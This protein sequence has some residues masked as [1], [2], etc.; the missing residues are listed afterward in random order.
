MRSIVAVVL[1]ML[2]ML[3]MAPLSSGGAE[4]RQSLNVIAFGGVSTIPLRVAESRGLFARHGLAVKVEITPNSVQ[5]REGLAKGTY[6]LAHAA[7]DNAVSMKEREGAD[8]VIVLG[9]DDSMN[10]LMVQGD[11]ASIK[12]LRGRTL[13]V[14][15]PTTAYALQMKHILL[16]GG[17]TADRDYTVEVVGG[18]PQRMDAMI[19]NKSYAA[20]MLNPPF[21]IQARNAGLKS[22]GSARELVGPYQGIGG[23]VRPAWAADHRDTLVHYIA[24]YVEGLRWFVDPANK[25]EAQQL[26]VATLKLAPDVAAET[27]ER[28]V[29]GGGLA[30]DAQIDM[31]GLRN[32]L[33]IRAEV[34]GKG[35]EAGSP[36]RYID[37]SFHQA[38]LRLLKQ[39]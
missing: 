34:E 15:A 25:S 10:E 24:A 16:N 13:I 28:A 39:P 3:T 18:T 38:A 35:Q 37:Q 12:D 27:Y 26:L 1:V 17:L 21:S 29:T 6:D 36:D 9:G 14:D 2:I 19:K 32:V 20:S 30:R 8:V 22:L 11:V 33:K 7:V 5:L 4:E 31:D 23:F